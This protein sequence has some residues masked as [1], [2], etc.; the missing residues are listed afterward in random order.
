MCNNERNNVI[1]KGKF[2]LHIS[3]NFV[4]NNNKLVSDKF[5]DIDDSVDINL[6]RE[7]IFEKLVSSFDSSYILENSQTSRNLCAYVHP[8]KYHLINKHNYR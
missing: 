3:F 7:N 5:D 1:M 6:I 4:L 2:S 8:R